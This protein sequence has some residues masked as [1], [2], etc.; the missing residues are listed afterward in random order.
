MMDV[1]LN[2]EVHTIRYGDLWWI[3]KCGA[4]LDRWCARH[5]HKLR[6]WTKDDIDPSY[7]AEK[8][9]C[10]D[11]LRQ[12]LA[13]DSDWLTYVDSDVF[14]SDDAPAHPALAGLSGIHIRRDDVIIENRKNRRYLKW[15]R[16]H[17]GEK[18]ARAILG[19]HYHNAGV[20]FCD[21]EAAARIIA[22]IERPYHEGIQEQHQWSYWLALASRRHGLE[23]HALPD[24]WNSCPGDPR[25]G[26]FLH[27][28]GR[29]KLKWAGVMRSFNQLPESFIP[30]FPAQFDFEPYRFTEDPMMMMDEY[31][32]HLLHAL[33]M[34]P[35]RRPDARNVAVEIGSCYGASTSALIEAVNNGGLTHL[36]IIETKPTDRLYRVV[37]HCKFPERV[38]I[39]VKD[40]SATDIAEADLVFIDGDHGSQ[41]LVD[42][43]WALTRGADIICTHD[44]RAWPR[45]KSCWGAHFASRLLRDTPGRQVV[46]DYED[47][48]TLRT[49][50]G[51]MISA[52]NGVDLSGIRAIGCE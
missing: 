10:V 31:H 30:K 9:C 21:R 32:I 52:A 37:G 33:A 1:D 7:P 44:S 38:T 41:A 42:V 27:L 3:R 14:V 18:A 45:I 15:I 11:M 16:K 35:A 20:W 5:G 24:A 36:H 26:H 22:V 12:F 4:S 39:H 50:R 40:C 17:F 25:K 23:C 28:L 34:I 47:R 6:V 48:P 43:L 49:W 8:F 13:G 46:E 2:I 29:D 19:C 51:F